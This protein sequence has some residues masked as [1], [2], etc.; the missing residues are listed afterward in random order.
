MLHKVERQAHGELGY[1]KG[2]YRLSFD[3]VIHDHSEFDIE[4]FRQPLTDKQ[5]RVELCC[6]APCEPNHA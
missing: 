1:L 6:K 4:Q 2:S 3:W 5:I